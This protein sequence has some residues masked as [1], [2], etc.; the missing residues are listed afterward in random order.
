M[1]HVP[2]PVIEKLGIARKALSKSIS[3]YKSGKENLYFFYRF[4][5]LPWELEWCDNKFLMKIGDLD[6]FCSQNSFSIKSFESTA[7]LKLAL[8]TKFISETKKYSGAFWFVRKDTKPKDLLRHLR[9]SFS[10]GNFTIGQR[11]RQ[12]CI[13]L[14][15]MDG[16]HIKAKGFIPLELL[17]SLVDSSSKCMV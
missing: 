3:Q 14:Q 13:N 9:N 8:D 5:V 11:N 4:V 6:D 7:K 10:H 2:A 12:K 17:K 1:P 15:N 16:N